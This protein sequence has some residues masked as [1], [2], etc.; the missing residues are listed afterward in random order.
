MSNIS[1]RI[2]E[3]DFEEALSRANSKGNYCRSCPNT[4]CSIRRNYIS[5]FTSEEIDLFLEEGASLYNWTNPAD[6]LENQLDE[7]TL[8]DF[9]YDPR[10]KL[11]FENGVDVDKL[12]IVKV[13]SFRNGPKTRHLVYSP[14]GFCPFYDSN[15]KSCGVYEDSRRPQVCSLYPLIKFSEDIVVIEKGSACQLGE[16][17]F[18]KLEK[19]LKNITERVISDSE[20]R[21]ERREEFSLLE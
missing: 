7:E 4:C 10:V 17:A 15:N 8:N 12:L 20:D 6:D 11:R 1:A 9:M 14:N 3:T 13:E 2:L 5:L 18:P 19:V 21:R 16:S